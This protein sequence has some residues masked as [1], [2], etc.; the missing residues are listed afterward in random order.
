[1]S[2]LNSWGIPELWQSHASAMVKTSLYLKEMV[3]WQGPNMIILSTI[4]RME[5]NSTKAGSRQFPIHGL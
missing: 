1:M 3:L 5:R 4:K 2:D